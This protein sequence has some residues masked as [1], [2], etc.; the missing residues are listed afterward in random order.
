MFLLYLLLK[1]YRQNLPPPSGRLY[2]N[3]LILNHL[4]PY[5]LEQLS[6]QYNQPL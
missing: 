5:R 6:G 3:S 4:Y 1:L 2:L